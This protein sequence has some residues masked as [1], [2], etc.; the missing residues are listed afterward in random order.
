MVKL[1]E[2]DITTKEILEWKGVHLLHAAQSSCSQKTRIF[3]NVKGIAWESHLIDIHGGEN[4]QPWFLGITPRGLVPVLVHDGEVHLESNDIMLYLEEQFP[5]PQLLLSDSRS[6]ATDLLNLEDDMHMDLRTLTF[7]YIAPIGKD[8]VKDPEAL[9]RL[10][11]N[12]GTIQGVVDRH[13]DVEIAFWEK[14]NRN[15]GITDE[16][17]KVSAVRFFEA[18][19]KLNTSLKGQEFVIGDAMSIVDIAW[20]VYVN[21]IKMTGYPLSLH[22]NLLAW[23]NRLANIEAFA[24]EINLPQAALEGIAAKQAEQA[25]RGDTLVKIANL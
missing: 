2:E 25:K 10:A 15:N 6:I 16:Q 22:P 8:Y 21:R 4:H 19:S 24:K 9:A 17:V 12:N 7:R 5:E 18:F 23:Y 1:V 11:E 13:K 14:A 20:F 3:L